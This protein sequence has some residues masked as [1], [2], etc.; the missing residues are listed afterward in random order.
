MNLIFLI[1]H[2]FEFSF[3]CKS[4][5]IL[6][7]IPQSLD[8]YFI[9]P[10]VF[11]PIQAVSHFLNRVNL[12]RVLKDGFQ[13]ELRV[14]GVLKP[15]GSTKLRKAYKAWMT[16]RKILFFIYFFFNNFFSFLL[17][18]AR[19]SLAGH[20]AGRFVGRHVL[21]FF[22]ITDCN[23]AKLAGRFDGQFVGRF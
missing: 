7:P 3:L 2:L 9:F 18:V 12:I 6:E 14:N 17:V 20:C 16:F 10:V 5:C 22:I 23:D 8:V 21:V 19:W 4:L 15:K 11:A 1:G 13:V